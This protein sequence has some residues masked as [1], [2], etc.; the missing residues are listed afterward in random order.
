M[1]TLYQQQLERLTNPNR[2]SELPPEFRAPIGYIPQERAEAIAS[3]HL[4]SSNPQLWAHTQ[5][6]ARQCSNLAQKLNLN[7][8]Q[9]TILLNAAWLYNIGQTNPNLKH[10]WAPG[11]TAHQLRIWNL[12]TVAALTIWAEA[13]PEESHQLNL[14]W[15]LSG[16]KQNKTIIADILNYAITTTSIT[17]N[18]ITP[19]KWFEQQETA[20]GP[21]SSKAK[22]LRAAWPRLVQG[23]KKI[24][25]SLAGLPG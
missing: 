10:D 15:E 25:N 3:D 6:L 11:N 24:I 12:E 16:H 18:E 14:N 23:N 13:N 19:N 4:A 2:A 21:L 22:A 7:Q 20:N 1:P 8:E 9:R 17:G 5:G